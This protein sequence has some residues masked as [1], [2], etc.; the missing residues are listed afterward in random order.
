MMR[1]HINDKHIVELSLHCLLACMSENARRIEFLDR[2]AALIVADQFHCILLFVAAA[3]MRLAL[4]QTAALCHFYASS[5]KDRR[6]QAELDLAIYHTTARLLLR[7]PGHEHHCARYTAMKKR[8]GRRSGFCVGSVMAVSL[9]AIVLALAGTAVRSETIEDFYKG[10]SI[11]MICPALPGGSYDLHARLVARHLSKWIPGHPTVIVQN[12]QGAG[13]LRATNYLYEKAP[14]NGTVLGVP[15]QENVL[16]DIIGGSKVRYDVAKFNWVGR[17]AVGVDAIVAWHTLGVKTINDAKKKSIIIAATGPASGTML[18]PLALNSIVGTKFKVVSGYKHSGM[19]LAVERGEA[20][21]AFSSLT[22]IKSLH[23]NWLPDKKVNV[24][25]MISSERNPEFAK[26]PTLAE[27]GR[28]AEDKQVLEIFASASTVG[29]SFLTTPNVPSERLAALR[30]AFAAMLKDPAFVSDFA[31]TK[32]EF[33]P[34]AGAALQKI[35]GDTRNVS[36]A[37]LAR[38]RAAIRP[39]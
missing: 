16:A 10:K 29:R 36:S 25:V 37:V 17:I 6:N 22:T 20:G 34:M 9:A 32:A 21:G 27:L 8:S 4:R 7:Q 24:L 33:A 30:T 15:V 23:P 39:K 5:A 35:I 14:Q 2:Y 26:V 1:I 38:V 18:Y 31:K 12:M 13:G 11:S 28:T 19:L 3:I